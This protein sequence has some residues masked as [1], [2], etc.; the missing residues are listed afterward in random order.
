MLRLLG[1]LGLTVVVYVVLV[2]I[3]FVG[4]AVG[5]VPLLGFFLAAMLVSA[6]LARF[7]EAALHRRRQHALMRELGAV[8]TPYN[9]GKLGLLLLQ[10]RRFRAAARLLAEAAEAE[11]DSAEWQ[12]RYGCALLGA[13]RAEEAI[14]P[15]ERAV[16]IDEEHAY[17]AA[18][19]RLAEARLAAGRTE[20]SLEA[21]D[22][23]DRNHGESPEGAYRRGLALRKL[24]RKDEARAAF[25]RVG[26][27]AGDAL[28]YQKRSSTVWSLRALVARLL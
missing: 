11:P 7:G 13:R 6:G 19:M 10:Q 20:E 12:Y 26:H 14:G 15:L 1:Y 5:T 25:S 4:G 3:P 22:G 18:M 24:G 9:K 8:D 21:L 23:L 28:G 17:G 27:L 2:N 16:A